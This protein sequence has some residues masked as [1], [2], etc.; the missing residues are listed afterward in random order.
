MPN[1]RELGNEHF[2]A[3]RFKEA[4]QQYTESILTVSRNDPKIFTNRALTRIRLQDWAGAE[5]DARKAIELHGDKTNITMKPH[6]YLAQALLQ[7]RRIGEALAEALQAYQICLET[8]DSSA[9]VISQHILRI[10]KMQWQT[11]E[12]L[13]IRRMEHTLALL[14]TLLEERL[15]K[16]LTELEERF[17]RGEIG[18]TGRDEEKAELEKEADERRHEVREKLGN[19]TMPNTADRVV[20]DYLIDPIT[21]EVMHDPVITPSGAS[22]ERVSLL[23][24]LRAHGTDPITRRPLSE[25]QLITNM[26][27]RNACAEFLENNGW[28][29]DW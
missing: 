22:Y 9:E 5:T 28:A 20:P 23:K 21:F 18:E 19:P 2:K 8:K 10:K 3:G 13:R 12:T 25:K 1:F 27:L 14:E 17:K 16:D 15:Q 4:E 11:K 7:Q 29:V 6:F 26:A 24:H